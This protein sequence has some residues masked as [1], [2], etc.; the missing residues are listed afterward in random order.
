MQSSPTPNTQA[1]LLLCA[2]LGEHH[3]PA[4]PLSTRQYS[5]LARWLEQHDLRPADL[6]E[7]HGRSLLSELALREVERGQIERLLD[8]GAALAMI[9]ERWTS[10]GLWILSVAD[11]EYPSRYTA[12]LQNAAPP[13]LFGVGERAPLNQ[14]GLAVVGSRHASEQDMAFARHIGEA[15]AAQK[16]AVISGAAKGID[17]ESMMAAMNAG[18]KAVGILAEG[19]GRAAIAGPYQEA[20]L[21]GRLTLISPYEPEARWQPYTAMDRNKLIYA[22]ADAALVI[23]SSDGEGGTWSGAVEALKKGHI[24]IY[25]KAS[26][27]V[28]AGNRK[29]IQSGAL[30]FPEPCDDFTRLF[31]RDHPAG[32]LF[33]QTVPTEIELDRGSVVAQLPRSDQAESGSTSA[34][35]SEAAAK[36]DHASSAIAKV[37]DLLAEPLG[38]KALASQMD[39]SQREVKS[40]VNRAMEEGLIRRVNTRYIR[41]SEVPTL[42]A[43]H[44]EP[45]TTKVP[46]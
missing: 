27:E 19:L 1:A 20:I 45:A 22:L 18:G 43:S 36:E 17:S 8:R 26:G 40:L 37:L 44:A 16:V 29:L 5:A 32:P 38:I 46:D 15:C 33:D 21:E 35:V 28:A 24:P 25:V 12:Y 3:A 41:T 2:K 11:E 42:F 7:H 34:P 9:V 13:V 30:E 39:I 4:K 23:A 10:R 6:L 31:V 14:G